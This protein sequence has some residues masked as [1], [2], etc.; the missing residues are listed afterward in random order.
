MVSP[1]AQYRDE[2]EELC[3]RY[4][5]RR[6]ELFGSAA[7]GKLNPDTIN[8][9]FLVMFEELE[10]AVYADAYQGFYES[11]TA[12][13]DHR[14]ELVSMTAITNPY[15]LECIQRNQETLYAA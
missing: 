13:F 8:I 9:D 1:I 10:P 15:F 14:I 3:R 11:L 2:M 6:L 5:A 7:S 12:L 4:H